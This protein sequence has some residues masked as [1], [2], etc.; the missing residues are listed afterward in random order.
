M[1]P[2]NILV[3]SRRG[4]PEHAY[5]TDFGIARAMLSAGTLTVAGQF[6]GTPDYAA[7]E[8]VNGQ[9]VDGRADQ[10]ALACVAFELLSGTVPFKRELPIAVLYAHLSTTPPLL[11][12]I[13]Q[14]VPPAV[15]EV[16]ARAMAKYPDERYP[17]CAD[18]ADALRE[19]LGLDPYDPS[20]AAPTPTM[21]MTMFDGASPSSRAPCRPRRSPGRRW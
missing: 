10:Y 19:A 1:K 6:L 12:A 11:T 20:R 15:D 16:L 7:P 21:P 8:Q 13:R 9:P 3:D 17:T 5:L 4:G 14:D 2:G 18:F